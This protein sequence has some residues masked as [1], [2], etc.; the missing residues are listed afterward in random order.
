MAEKRGYTVKLLKPFPEQK[1]LEVEIDGEWYRATSK[2]F[3]SWKGK[4]RIITGY[5]EKREPI[6]EEYNGPVFQEG[7]NKTI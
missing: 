5:D 6:Y 2:D 4:R 1:C 7:T 3:R